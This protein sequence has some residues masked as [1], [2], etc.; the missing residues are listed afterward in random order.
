[1]QV[2]NFYNSYGDSIRVSTIQI[3]VLLRDENRSL[4]FLKCNAFEDNVSVTFFFP[5]I[6]YVSV[7]TLL[8]KKSKS[9]REKRMNFT[10][11]KVSYCLHPRLNE[12][13][14]YY[15]IRKYK[16]YIK[17]QFSFLLSKKLILQTYV[18]TKT[19]ITS[20]LYK[21]YNFFIRPS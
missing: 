6:E 10:D 14:F 16:T 8:S 4:G 5:I 3:I 19:F 13:S 1:M 12:R 7:C 2:Q 15:F 9:K 11:W 20:W 18:S 21:I 17:L